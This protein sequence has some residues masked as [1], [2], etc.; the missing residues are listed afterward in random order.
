MRQPTPRVKSKTK[1]TECD[2]RVLETGVMLG[3]GQSN[4][5][6]TDTWRLK[7]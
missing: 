2:M 5:E 3:K 1:P 4:K 6:V 7:T